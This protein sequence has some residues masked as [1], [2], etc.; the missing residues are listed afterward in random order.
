[1]T[2]S[3]M[4]AR[5]QHPHHPVPR[6]LFAGPVNGGHVH[7]QAGSLPAPLIFGGPV[8]GGHGRA[9]AG[10]LLAP[11]VFGGNTRSPT[12]VVNAIARSPAASPP[13]ESLMPPPSAAPL[14]GRTPPP[15]AAAAAGPVVAADATSLPSTFPS[16]HVPNLDTP[17]LRPNTAASVHVPSPSSQPSRGCTDGVTQHLS[18]P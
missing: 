12:H 15:L 1:M 3:T 2:T 6:N 14:R 17:Q 8:S 7:A 4:M 16:S 10:S 11:L 5:S 13:S 9:Q 18:P